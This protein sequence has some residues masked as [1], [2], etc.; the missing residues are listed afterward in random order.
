MKGA[1]IVILYRL[2]DSFDILQVRNGIYYV[3]L[4]RRA[5]IRKGPI[6]FS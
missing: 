6:V 5:R 1:V 3:V 2:L 4:N